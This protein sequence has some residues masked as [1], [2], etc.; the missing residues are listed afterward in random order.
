MPSA[1][2]PR[3]ASASS[4]ATATRSAGCTAPPPTGM[5]EPG[6]PTVL[7][8]VG[9]V[10]ATAASLGGERWRWRKWAVL[11]IAV[12]AVVFLVYTAARNWSRLP[13]IQWRFEPAWLVACFVA[14]VVFQAIQAQL[15]MGIL[16]ALGGRLGTAR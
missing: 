4:T 13:D 16:R 5:A 9:S 15:W 8:R 3:C 2:R 11:A 14:L 1:S 10:G 12:L 6:R 7:E